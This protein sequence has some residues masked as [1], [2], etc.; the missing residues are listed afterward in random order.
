MNLTN[1]IQNLGMVIIWSKE[2][3]KKCVWEMC[4]CVCFVCVFVCQRE[5]EYKCYKSQCTFQGHCMAV[6]GNHY[7]E[8]IA[9]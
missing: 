4:F 9:A 8:Y 6:Y 3:D 2:K 7:I 5:L 1:L